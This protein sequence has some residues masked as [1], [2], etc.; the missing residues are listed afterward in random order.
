M[1]NL[2]K[3]I[4][5]LHKYNRNKFGRSQ[6][7]LTT[8]TTTALAKFT[9]Q[10]ALQKNTKKEVK[11]RKLEIVI[12]SNVKT[13]NRITKIVYKQLVRDCNYKS[14]ARY[15]FLTEVLKFSVNKPH[16]MRVMSSTIICRY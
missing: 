12:N 5:Y 1:F 15:P 10:A 4:F 11:E 13:K 9:K 8:M 2:T 16:A 14:V 6:I 3:K 7:N